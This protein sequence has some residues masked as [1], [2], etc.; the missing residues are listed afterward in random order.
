MFYKQIHSTRTNKFAPLLWLGVN[1][2]V[3]SKNLDHKLSGVKKSMELRFMMA[4]VTIFD[5]L[6][7]PYPHLIL[8]HYRQ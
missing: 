5:A 2:A 3:Y 6:H 8:T 1:A 4:L 7:F